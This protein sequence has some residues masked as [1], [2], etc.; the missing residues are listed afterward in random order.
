MMYQTTEFGGTPE[1][2]CAGEWKAVPQKIAGADVVLAGTPIT[3][4][5]AAVSS[6]ATGAMGILLYD[7]DPTRNPNGAVVV[8]GIIDLKKANAHSG[9][10]LT[11]AQIKAAVP[12][13]VCRE[14][15]GVNA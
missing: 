7:V 1:I 8:E 9:L 6:G 14:N 10:A 4:A 3:A 5:G 13:I 2:L 15:I 12:T 11:A